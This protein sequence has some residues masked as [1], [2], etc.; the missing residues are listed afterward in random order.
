MHKLIAVQKI[1]A[2]LEQAW[3]LFSNPSNLGVITPASLRFRVLTPDISPTVFAGQVIEYRVSPLLGI[4]LFWKTEITDVK[5]Y[6]C[7]IDE[8]RKGPYAR[9]H[10][11]HYF[12]PIEGGVEMTDLVEY[13]NPLGILG[14]WANKWLVR[15]KLHAIFTYRYHK[16][17]ELLGKWEGQEPM[18]R[19]E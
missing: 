13:K 14:K 16:V 2:T 19:F 3:E 11:A 8:Q 15:K 6:E 4:P 7:F 12:K 10:H 5:D 18:I 1:P 9:W 17:E